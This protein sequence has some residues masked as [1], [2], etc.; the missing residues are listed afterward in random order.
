MKFGLETLEQERVRILRERIEL[1]ERLIHKTG[2]R[3]REAKAE[4]RDLNAQYEAVCRKIKEA[5]NE[6]SDTGRA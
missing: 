3:R 6:T 1:Y 4:L 5:Q 2:K